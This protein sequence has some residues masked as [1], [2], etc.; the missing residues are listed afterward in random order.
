MYYREFL[1]KYPDAKVVLTV[2]DAAAWY[3]SAAS[4]IFRPMPA[5]IVWLMKLSALFSKRMR[6]TLDCYHY[7]QDIVHKGFF[8]NKIHDP[9]ACQAIFDAWNEEVK[10]TVPPEKLLIFQVKDGWEPLCRFLGV[11]VPDEPFPRSNESKGFVKNVLKKSTW[12]EQ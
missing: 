12:L 8:E 10:R 6:G 3:G 5:P 11:P 9:A 1:E 2:R 4:T 7:A